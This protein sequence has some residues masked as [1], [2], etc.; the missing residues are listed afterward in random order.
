[1]QW[2]IVYP[3][4]RCVQNECDALISIDMYGSVQHENDT[5]CMPRP[6]RVVRK[7][8]FVAINIALLRSCCEAHGTMLLPILR[9][10]GAAANNNQHNERG[11][12]V[13]EL[14]THNSKST[15]EAWQKQF[16]GLEAC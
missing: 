3:V 2:G 10:S 4:L 7:G 1:M 6:Y 15:Q 9:S 5:R 16:P 13:N 12:V 14:K 8:G 11:F